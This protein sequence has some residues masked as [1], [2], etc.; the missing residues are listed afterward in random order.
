[1]HGVRGEA[2]RAEAWAKPGVDREYESW[3]K[4][5][6]DLCTVLYCCEQ[7]M[8]ERSMSFPFEDREIG[9]A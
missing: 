4:D 1:M 7:N 8:S 2:G 5:A 9:Y 6:Y 3:M